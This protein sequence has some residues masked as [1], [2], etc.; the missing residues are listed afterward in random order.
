MSYFYL[1]C[2]F[3]PLSEAYFYSVLKV[4]FVVTLPRSALCYISFHLASKF[5]TEIYKKI[6]N[7]CSGLRFQNPGWGYTF[8]PH[9]G[10]RTPNPMTWP[11]NLI[12]LRFDYD[13]DADGVKGNGN[14]D[15]V[16]YFPV[17]QGI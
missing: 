1:G 10:L 17:D 13:Q 9:C 6:P 15:G 7:F 11:P 8:G 2:I 5:Y 4:C 14:G 3:I 12:S 16:S